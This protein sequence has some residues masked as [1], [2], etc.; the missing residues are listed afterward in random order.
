MFL[1]GIDL[2]LSETGL[3]FNMTAPA[4]LTVA[5]QGGEAKGRVVAPSTAQ[6][7]AAGVLGARS[8]CSPGRIAGRPAEAG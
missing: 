4:D 8:A 7:A 2:L 5:G 6:A 1:A 3:A